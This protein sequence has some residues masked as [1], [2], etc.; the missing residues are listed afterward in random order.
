MHLRVEYPPN[1]PV[2][3]LV[4]SLKGVLACRL[5][6]EYTGRVNPASMQGHFW[7]PVLLRRLGRR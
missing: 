2:S 5:R 1:V 7:S 4:N 3:A 6:S